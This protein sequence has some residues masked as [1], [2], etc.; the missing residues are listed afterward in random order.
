MA[1]PAHDQRD[2]EF[3]QKFGLDIIPVVDVPDVDLNNLT[4]AAAAEGTM[5][6]SG[7]YDGLNNNEAIVKRVYELNHDETLYAEFLSQPKL[8]PY[9]VD[10][11][12][13]KFF[14]LKEKLTELAD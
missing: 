11:V 7:E 8:L 13:E 2:F 5:I 9:T 6:N 12:Y 14:T 4:E 10:Y 1:V 3:A